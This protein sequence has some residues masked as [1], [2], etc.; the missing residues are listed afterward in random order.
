MYTEGRAEVQAS[1]VAQVQHKALGTG[2]IL[3]TSEI[4]VGGDQITGPD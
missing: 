2:A 1:I 3:P 4:Q